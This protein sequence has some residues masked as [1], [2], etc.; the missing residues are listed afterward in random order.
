MIEDFFTLGGFFF[1]VG[2]GW[3]LRIVSEQINKQKGD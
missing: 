1:L 2:L 3:F